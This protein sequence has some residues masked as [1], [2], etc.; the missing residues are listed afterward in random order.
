MTAEH[1]ARPVRDAGLWFGVGAGPVLWALHLFAIYYVIS[2]G[3]SLDGGV[4]KLILFIFTAIL[5]AVVAAA[6]VLSWRWFGEARAAGDSLDGTLRRP[7]FMAMAGVVLSVFFALGIAFQAL[8][9]AML[10]AFD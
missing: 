6:G 7:A 8:P 2:V 9:V 3:R 5:V 10:G 1:D 4:L